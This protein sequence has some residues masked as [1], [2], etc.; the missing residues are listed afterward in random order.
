MIKRIEWAIT[1]LLLV[2]TL[3]ICGRYL[4]EAGKYAGQREVIEMFCAQV[5]VTCPPLPGD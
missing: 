3:I 1:A 2:A 4:Y 5:H